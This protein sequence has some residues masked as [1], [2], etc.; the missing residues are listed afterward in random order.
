MLPDARSVIYRVYNLKIVT[1]FWLS[2]R[3]SILPHPS[4]LVLTIPIGHDS[5]E[6]FLGCM[7][8]AKRDTNINGKLLT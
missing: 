3:C 1:H 2:V 6:D 8:R 4:D 5:E 7:I